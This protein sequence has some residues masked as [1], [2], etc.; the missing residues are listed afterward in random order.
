MV[1]PRFTPTVVLALLACALALPCASAAETRPALTRIMAVGDSITEGGETFSC[2]RPSLREK[3]QAA[4][5][6]VEYVGTLTSP[7]PTGPLAHEGYGGK[8][9]EFLA[10]TV[11]EHFR[12]NPADIV[13]LHSGHNHTVEEHP[14]AGIVAATEKLITVFRAINPR[15]T[16]LLAQ[17]IPAG[18]LPKYSYLPEL[19]LA[20]AQLAARLDQ[21]QQRVIL[22]DHAT[23][24]DWQ[25]DTVADKVH[26]NA[27]GAEKMASAWFAALV[28]VLPKP[29][30]D[31]TPTPRY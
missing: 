4:G 15:V 23:G 3:L 7:S 19:N 11:P 20:L 17:V 22:V 9:T 6:R 14:V 5:Y 27:R 30:P 10:A 24:F 18:K 26:P 13:L 31:P 28:A 8:N 16:V 25:S 1:L 29:T 2:Y 12:E 21:P